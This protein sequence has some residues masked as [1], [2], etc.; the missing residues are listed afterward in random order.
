MP[1]SEESQRFDEGATSSNIEPLIKIADAHFLEKRAVA[2]EPGPNNSFS[3]RCSALSDRGVPMP[4]T[5][6]ASQGRETYI[7][8]YVVFAFTLTISISPT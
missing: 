4:L 2:P 5:C 6:N 8:K 7:F 3:C 1:L